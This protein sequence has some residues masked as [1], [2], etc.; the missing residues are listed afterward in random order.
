MMAAAV[1]ALD[2]LRV[3]KRLA[4]AGFTSAQAEAVTSIVSEATDPVVRELV[5]RKDLQIE[6]APL[7]ADNSLMKWMIGVNSAMLLAMLLKQ[8]LPA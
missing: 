5:T 8:F 1:V 2:T 7:R 4:E 3:S 6:L